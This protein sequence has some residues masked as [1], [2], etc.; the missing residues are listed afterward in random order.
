MSLLTISIASWNTKELTRQ[1]IETIIKNTQMKDYE[2]IVIDNAS[3]DGSVD[4]IRECFPQVKVIQN[5]VNIGF[6][7][8]HNK[9]ARASSG[10]YF[11][12]LNSDVIVLPGVFDKMVEFLE[13]RKDYSVVTNKLLNV[14]MTLQESIAFFPVLWFEF[15][16]RVP[17]VH[18]FYDVHKPFDHDKEQ[19]IETFNG[20]CYIV[21]RS[22]FEKAGM[23]DESLFA[24]MEET[25]LFFRMK[26]LKMKIRYLPEVKII[27]YG[28]ASTASWADKNIMYYTNLLQFFK[29]EY[30]DLTLFLVRLIVG[31]SNLLSISKYP[32][33]KII[34][35]GRKKQLELREMDLAL[36][37]L[38][39]NMTKK[40]ELNQ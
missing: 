14:D 27:H 3:T 9:V 13:T 10:K 4:M 16:S 32:V 23:F 38:K 39:I 7:S 20:A 24:Y 8:A 31:F 36:K 2:I 28:G 6:G 15:I 37:L 18:Y 17:C 35:D 11:C 26:R 25:D 21:R 33:I 34:P 1:T 5:K 19:D 29:K 40:I 30:G 22:D 12:I